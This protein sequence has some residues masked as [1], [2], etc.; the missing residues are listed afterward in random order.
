MESSPEPQPPAAATIAAMAR[1]LK[2][3]LPRRGGHGKPRSGHG[4]DAVGQALDQ[5]SQAQA[6]RA[7]RQRT[8]RDL[9]EAIPDVINVLDVVQSLWP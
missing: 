8:A 2:A 3:A 5:A 6:S 4:D 1:R 9:A 7:K